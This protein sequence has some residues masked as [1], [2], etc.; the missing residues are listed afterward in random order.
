MPSIASCPSSSKPTRNRESRKRRSWYLGGDGFRGRLFK[1]LKQALSKGSPA[2][3]SGEAKRAHAEAEAARLLT[4][5]MKVLGVR[6]GVLE[7]APKNQ[8]QKQ[9]L[10]WWLR[11]RTTVGRRWIS[12]RLGMGKESGLTRAVRLV[13][14]NPDAEV[15]RLKEQLRKGVTE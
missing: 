15:K 3:F 11:Q 4:Q 12:Q 1:S 6:A 7:R 14:T 10:A 13:K 8:R 5:G 2:S 9:V